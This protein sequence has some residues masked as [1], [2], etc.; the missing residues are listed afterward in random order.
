MLLIDQF[1][2]Y[3]LIFKPWGEPENEQIDYFFF[4]Y[5]VNFKVLTSVGLVW[6]W[7]QGGI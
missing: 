2:Y 1:S 7:L 3:K 4:N 6:R 5:S